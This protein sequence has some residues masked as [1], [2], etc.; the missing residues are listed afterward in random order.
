MAAGYHIRQFI[1]SLLKRMLGLIT[2]TEFPEPV[3]L[4][5]KGD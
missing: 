1:S 5:V 2:S 4:D 3:F